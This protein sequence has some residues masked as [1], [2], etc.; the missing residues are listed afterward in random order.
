MKKQS[1]EEKNGKGLDYDKQNSSKRQPGLE[2]GH[3]GIA[4]EIQVKIIYLDG[5]RSVFVHSSTVWEKAL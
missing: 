1:T 4:I 2:K 5:A 3:P